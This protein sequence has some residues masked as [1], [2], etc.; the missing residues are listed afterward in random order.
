MNEAPAIFLAE[1]DEVDVML[2]RRAF[3]TAGLD[4]PLEVARDGQALVDRLEQLSRERQ[5]PPP[6]LVILDLKMPRRDGLQTLQWLRAHPQLC[7]V[8]VVIFS[9]SAQRVDL[10]RA[11]ELGANA[12][13]VKPP[14]LA[15]RAEVA[16]F[17]KDW[18]RLNRPAPADA[19]TSD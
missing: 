3:S 4:A 7:H 19:W 6:S 13:L 11:Y 14:S 15:E 9:S 10:R 12:F 16:R 17:L 2:L 1:D 5:D 8:P 18:L